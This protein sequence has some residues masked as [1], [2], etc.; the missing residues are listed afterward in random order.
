MCARLIRIMNAIYHDK[1]SA[2]F[3]PIRKT[4]AFFTGDEV[5]AQDFMAQRWP[6][7]AIQSNRVQE[8]DARD[9]VPLLDFRPA[10]LTE[11]LVRAEQFMR[12]SVNSLEILRAVEPDIRFFIRPSQQALDWV[13]HALDIAT[14]IQHAF[15]ENDNLRMKIMQNFVSLPSAL[16]KFV[17][18]ISA[19]MFMYRLRE[20][21]RDM[22]WSWPS[23]LA[24]ESQ[25]S[26]DYCPYVDLIRE[27]EE[28]QV[29][30]DKQNSSSDRLRNS[31]FAT[32]CTLVNEA[33][34]VCSNVGGLKP[35]VQHLG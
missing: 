28:I 24:T 35:E 4:P 26:Y 10:E 8:I 33:F 22:R 7:H 21:R 31:N 14:Q 13:R 16:A 30:L 15:I 20:N 12:S 23:V 3:R 19:V 34:S 27:L 25:D 1:S 29:L 32:S 17:E 6:I 11:A 5:F 9:A 18:L 2:A